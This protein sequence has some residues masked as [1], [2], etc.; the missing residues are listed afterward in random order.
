M[1]KEQT[2]YRDLRKKLD[3]ILYSLET[4][5]LDIDEAIVLHKKGQEVVASMEKYLEEVGQAIKNSTKNK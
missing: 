5:D 3:E 2:S 1:A 4:E